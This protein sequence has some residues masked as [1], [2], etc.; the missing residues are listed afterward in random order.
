[1]IVRSVF[2]RALRA[3]LFLTSLSIAQWAFDARAEEPEAA[4][5]PVK[6]VVLYNAG[7]GF[8]ERRA[9]IEGNAKVDLKF[10]S[11]E[12]NDLLKSMVLQDLGGGKISTVTYASIDPITKTLKTFAIDLT[13]N[14]T[15]ANLLDQV[16]GEKVEIEAP[17]RVTGTILGV[18]TREQQ[19]GDKDRVVKTEFL[20]LL[21]ETG[22][23]SFPMASISRIKLTDAKLDTELRQALNVLALGHAT[24]K[25]TVSVNFEGEGKR[26]V[27]VGYI[28][29]SPIWRT[30][31]RLV[32]SDKKPP[33]LQ[34]WALVENTSE[35]DWQD[36]NLTLVS[37]R[38]ISFVMNL[39]QPLYV[40][41]PVVE[42][43]LFG[44]LRPQVYGQNMDAN[45]SDFAMAPMFR[46]GPRAD[47]QLASQGRAGGLVISAPAPAAQAEVESEVVQLNNQLNLSRGIATAAAGADV[48]ELFQYRIESPVS[49]SRQQSAMLPI[50]NG[51]VQGEK[52]SIYNAN[53]Q[54]KHPLNGLRLKNT[55]E[56]HLM[57]GPVTV[58]DDGTYAG[59]ARIEDLPPGSERLISYALDLDIEVVPEAKSSPEQLTSVKI[60]KGTLTSTRKYERT[61][62]YTVKNS[63]KHGKSVLIEYP[64]DANWKLIEPKEPTEKTRDM[65]RFAVTAEPGKPA[66]LKI[67]EEQ[68]VSQQMVLGN[69]PDDMIVYYQHSTAVS[70][71]VKKALAEVV[72]RKQELQLLVT[73]RQ[74]QEQII[75]VITQ[76]QTRIRENMSRLDRNN[77]LYA[78]YVKK[79]SEQEDQVEKAHAQIDQLNKQIN[80]RQKALDDYLL[81]L[82]LS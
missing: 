58:F 17:N 1:M 7:V 35:E 22:L 51:A 45:A 62:T 26:P 59:D 25:K 9:D 42:S 28:Q 52:L 23:R 27:R 48:G 32:L 13:N 71:G 68:T 82:D 60:A 55:T 29:Q 44:S 19:V 72:K 31:Y 39:Y 2:C 16:R 70:D 14:P 53:V 66:T 79:F 33:F 77:D 73:Q 81:S 18:E 5:L 36:V 80:E 8:F 67:V 10:N 6:R 21:T 11:T 3:G 20:N 47:K 50:V 54:P 69:L 49:L 38:P 75:A 37:G 61:Q 78:R 76:E 43:E 15:M 64:F 24:D 46:N 56:L 34:G 30:T 41:R 65:Y 12:I 74:E 57:Q 63:G 4:A 40:N